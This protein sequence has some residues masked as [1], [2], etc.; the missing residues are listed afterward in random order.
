MG[1][2]QLKS[3]Y[4]TWFTP[5]EVLDRHSRQVPSESLIRTVASSLADGLM[6]AIAETMVIPPNAPQSYFELA[7]R[8]WRHWACLSDKDFWSLG[9]LERSA[10]SPGMREAGLP[11]FRA[12]RVRLERAKVEQIMGGAFGPATRLEAM[13]LALRE[14]ETGQVF[15]QRPEPS[16][17]EPPRTAAPADRD[18]LPKVD[19][20]ALKA[21]IADF[22]ARNPGA[23]FAVFRDNAK[24]AFPKFRVG[25]RPV[26]AAI[27]ECG[28]KLKP[29]NPTIQRK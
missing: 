17:P 18:L 16:R 24:L 8:V 10:E 23:S 20:K 15:A 25:E 6:R 26:Q 2:D 28:F 3:E 27:A 5:A 29:G 7:P 22:G 9:T 4:D 21:W 14:S 1:E 19:P 13:A 12:Y 11:R